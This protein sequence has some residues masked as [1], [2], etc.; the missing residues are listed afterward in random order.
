MSKSSYLLFEGYY[1]Y[2]ESSYKPS[3]SYAR[4][5]SPTFIKPQG[6]AGGCVELYYHM[7]GV[8]IGTLNISV[9]DNTQAGLVANFQR[10]GQCRQT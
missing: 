7:Y 9:Y 5:T 2:I 8:D 3:G 10:T 1:M 6:E 4:L